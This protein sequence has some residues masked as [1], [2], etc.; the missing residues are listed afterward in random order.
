[1]GRL[2]STVACE[3]LQMALWRRR[4]AEGQLIF[5]S[6]RGVQYASDAFGK[7][8][9]AHGIEGSMSRKGDCWDDA[10]VESFFGTLKS[11][12]VHWRSYQSREEARADIVEYITM[13]YNSRRL[14]SYLAYQSP[15]E[16]ERKGQL[17]NA[18]QRGVRFR[19][20]T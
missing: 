1:M 6:D 13:F 19:L 3:A 17:A 4:P 9:E 7:L 10:V 11:E 5:H 20:T 15:D 8:L 16:F 18:P 12:R 2:T 14:H